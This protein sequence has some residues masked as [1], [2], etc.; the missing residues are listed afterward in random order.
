MHF[1]IRR[2]SRDVAEVE[3]LEGG[4]GLGPD[5]VLLHEV[6]HR[7]RE[8]AHRREAGAPHEALQHHAAGDGHFGAF[9]F[10]LFGGLA[11]VLRREVA[12]EVLAFEVVRVGDAGRADS[13]QLRASFRHDGV[14]GG[15]LNLGFHFRHVQ[16]LLF[17]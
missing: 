8:V 15:V 9:G 6:L 2:M 17:E 5:R 7:A 12:E 11:A 14:L 4:V 10:E 16:L 3:L 1:A 13:L